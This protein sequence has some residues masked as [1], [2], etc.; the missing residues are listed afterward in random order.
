MIPVKVG[1]NDLA[2]WILGQTTNVMV[3]RLGGR[4]LGVR[5]HHHDAVVGEDDSGIRVH[6]ILG[7]RDGSIDA[8]GHRFELEEVLSDRLGVARQG[9]AQIEMIERLD[10]CSRNP[11]TTQ[12]L[13]T[14]PV[15]VHRLS[16]S[17]G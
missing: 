7:S 5:I 12:K 11:D 6:F 16:S 2:Y 3:E 9:T 1:V 15:C 4:W 8:V 13:S 14:R 10:G 17:H